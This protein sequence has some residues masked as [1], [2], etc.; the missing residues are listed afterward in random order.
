MGTVRYI[1]A[2]GVLISHFN[3]L[4]GCHVPWVVSSYFRVGGFFTLSGFVLLG[5][6]LRGGSA[7]N[8]IIRRAWRILPSYFFVV[9]MAAIGLVVVSEL[10]AADY[11]TSSGFWKYLAA[12]LSFLN[13]LHPDLPGVFTDLQ[14]RAVNGALW[15]MKVEWQLSLC[16]P[17]FVWLCRRFNWN[18][19]KAALVVIAVSLLYRWIFLELYIA[20]ERS[21]YEILGR[22]FVGQ[23]LFFFSGIVLYCFY[24][25]LMRRRALYF[26]IALAI[27]VP[28]YLFVNN[29]YF[30]ILAFPFLV[31]ALT[32]TAS[33]IPGDFAAVIDRGHN[34]SY[35]IY[36]CHF[37]VVQLVASYGL[38]ARIG[39]VGAFVVCVAGTLAAAVITYFTVGRMYLR[40]KPR[41]V[42]PEGQNVAV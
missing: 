13:F 2:F 19:V 12:N 37:P 39:T 11:F 15:T 42:V 26:S 1:L 18:L 7:K 10:P 35:E 3:V 23:T 40:H 9:L 29:Y 25:K 24:E 30:L 36:L 6:L 8:F 16:A 21:I 22:Q 20:T 17:L 34:I 41:P 31:S 5:S 33:L 27:Y 14:E 32:L 38:V 28:L 4:C